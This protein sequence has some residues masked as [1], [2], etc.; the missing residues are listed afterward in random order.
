MTN[1][2]LC[3]FFLCLG[4]FFKLEALSSVMLFNYRPLFPMG[5]RLEQQPC[6]AGYST[7]KRTFQFKHAV[8]SSD[9]GKAYNYIVRPP[10]L[11]LGKEMSLM[12]QDLLCKGS[13]PKG[14]G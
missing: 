11:M 1:A 7:Y 2:V 12:G 10:W 3:A 14:R 6:S 4:L 13:E 5:T 9:P 8:R